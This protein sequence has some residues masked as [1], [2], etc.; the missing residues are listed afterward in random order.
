MTTTYSLISGGRATTVLPDQ[1][2]KLDLRED[3]A[4]AGL[5]WAV[6]GRGSS[7]GLKVSWRCQC[8]VSG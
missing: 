7:K 2:L 4:A 1:L 3:L 8:D 5:R 6:T